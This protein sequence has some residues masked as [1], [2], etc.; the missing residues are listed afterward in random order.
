MELKQTE[1]TMPNCRCGGTTTMIKTY[2]EFKSTFPEDDDKMEIFRWPDGKISITLIG[3][4]KNLYGENESFVIDE[5][6]LI[7]GIKKIPRR[8]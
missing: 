6:E 3:Q 4:E 1:D 8:G 7:E 2:G 5:E